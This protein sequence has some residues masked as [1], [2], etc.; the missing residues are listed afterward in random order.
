MH[1]QLSSFYGQWHYFIM[2]CAVTHAVEDI[3]I[4]HHNVAIQTHVKHLRRANEGFQYA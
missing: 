2:S 3:E 4:L 1:T